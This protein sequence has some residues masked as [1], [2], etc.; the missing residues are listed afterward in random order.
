[1]SRWPSTKARRVLAALL[2]ARMRRVGGIAIGH[3]GATNGRGFMAAK[4]LR[5]MLLP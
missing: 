4:C 1:M 5:Q 2:V 3:R